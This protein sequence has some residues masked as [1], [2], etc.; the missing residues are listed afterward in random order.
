MKGNWKLITSHK[1]KVY[2]GIIAFFITS[3]VTTVTLFYVLVVSDH[4]HTSAEQYTKMELLNREVDS[5]AVE[6]SDSVAVKET[7]ETADR[8]HTVYFSQTAIQEHVVSNPEQTKVKNHRMNDSQPNKHVNTPKP[9]TEPPT[10][11][12]P[13]APVEPV[14]NEPAPIDS[15]ESPEPEPETPP[16]PEKKNCCGLTK[17]FICRLNKS[18]PIKEAPYSTTCASFY[19]LNGNWL[20]FAELGRDLPCETAFRST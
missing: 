15:P 12:Q 18:Y 17:W 14:P 2:S 10:S 5:V 4:F 11:D 1:K 19:A 6:E 16:E 9:R 7:K 3:L 8:G 13:K 20:F